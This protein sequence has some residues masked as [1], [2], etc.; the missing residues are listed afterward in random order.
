MTVVRERPAVALFIPSLE[1]GG[2]ERQVLELAKALRLRAW[3]VLVVTMYPTGS[4]VAYRD[5]DGDIAY[6]VVCLEKKGALRFLIRFQHLIKER[7]IRIVHAYLGTAQ[8][9]AL[10]V[11]V[12][13]WRLK[14]IF[15]IRDALPLFYTKSIRY[16][17]CDLAIFCA[18]RMVK[19]YVFNSNAGAIAKGR[20]VNRAQKIV[21]PNFIDTEKFRPNRDMRTRVRLEIGISEAELI[22]MVVA[23]VTPYKD[24]TTFVASAKRVSERCVN[25]LFIVVGDATG[26]YAE[27]IK[28]Q[29]RLS[30]M[31]SKLRFLGARSDVEDLL[32]AADVYCSSS[33]TEAFSNSIGE[34][35]ACGVPCVVT[36]V[37]DSA[38]IVGDTGFV[39]PSKDVEALAQGLTSVLAMSADARRQLGAE[40]RRRV[41]ECFSSQGLVGTYEAIYQDAFKC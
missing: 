40:A 22:V 1:R 39:V 28:A 16:V 4:N 25:A 2:A 20:Y 38:Q 21:V 26:S 10:A 3:R 41:I 5:V 37:G 8:I 12:S 19:K 27:S 11:K 18:T 29:V 23:N 33:E 34:A 35:M 32:V 7:D 14:L 30:G 31:E 15:G 6:E 9:Y 13:L 17:L 24:Y 36:D